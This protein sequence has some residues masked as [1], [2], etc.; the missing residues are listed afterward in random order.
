MLSVA[1][2]AAIAVGAFY[3]F[4]G[5]VVLRAMMLNRVMDRLLAA[6]NDPSAPREQMKSRVLTAGGVL[7]LAS[8]AALALLSPL[9]AVLFT[10]NALWQGG[11]LLWAERALPPEDASDA[12]GR[13]QTKN[14]FVVYLAATAFVMW[15]AA[16]GQLRP[17]DAPLQAYAI[18]A[19]A[20][21]VAVAV[22]WLSLT[23]RKGGIAS[24]EMDGGDAEGQSQDDARRWLVMRTDGEGKSHLVNDELTATEACELAESLETQ[25]PFATYSTHGY[26]DWAERAALLE[27]AGVR[28]DRRAPAEL[29]VTRVRLMP[30][31]GCSPLW[32]ADTGEPVSPSW[33][34]DIEYE[35]AERIEL[36]DDSWQA[37]FKTDDPASSGFT[38]AAAQAAYVAEG[39]EIV[40]ALRTQWRGELVE[41]AEEFR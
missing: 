38:D 12:R 4:A 24:E 33:L 27:H 14:A 40:A 18:D 3:V 41:I 29:E 5:Y 8:G 15:L 25:E 34:A 11:Y 2:Y 31:Y 37:T 21:L 30:S 35:L 17:W 9:A 10:A 36:W 1:Q 13:Q 16:Q 28:D 39:R 19:A 26:S 22:V 23:R 6:L 32:N 20:V 7:T